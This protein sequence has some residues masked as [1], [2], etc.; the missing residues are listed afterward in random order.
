[1]DLATASGTE[2]LVSFV[3]AGFVRNGALAGGGFVSLCRG[4]RFVTKRRSSRDLFILT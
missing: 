3:L 4:A 2:G 1:M